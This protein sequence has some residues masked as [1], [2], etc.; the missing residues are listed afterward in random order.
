MGHHFQAILIWIECLIMKKTLP[1]EYQRF[2]LTWTNFNRFLP[3]T[4]EHVSYLSQVFGICSLNTPYQ[5]FT[6]RRLDNFKFMKFKSDESDRKDP[7]T[8]GRKTNRGEN[9]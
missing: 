6:D 3:I 9:L 1:T 2:F 4:V 8:L 5:S 7:E